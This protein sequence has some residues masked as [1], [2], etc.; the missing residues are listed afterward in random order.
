MTGRVYGFG[1]KTV[2]FHFHRSV[3]R[4]RIPLY[5]DSNLYKCQVIEQLFHEYVAIHFSTNH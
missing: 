4:D 2:F 5:T 1:M 3:F